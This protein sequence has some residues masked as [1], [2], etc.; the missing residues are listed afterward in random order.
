M[1]VLTAASIMARGFSGT[2]PWTDVCSVNSTVFTA[3]VRP[4]HFPLYTVPHAPLPSTPSSCS[5][6]SVP[7]LRIPSTSCLM[8]SWWHLSFTDL[9][10][11]FA[12]A[13]VTSRRGMIESPT[14][15]SPSSL[16]KEPLLL[17]S[18]PSSEVCCCPAS[19]R[20]SLSCGL[21]PCLLPVTLSWMSVLLPVSFLDICD[22][23]EAFGPKDLFS[24]YS[25][26]MMLMWTLLEAD[27]PQA[28][29][30]HFRRLDNIA[31]ATMPPIS[32]MLAPTPTPTP[33]ATALTPFPSRSSSS[34]TRSS[35][36]SDSRRGML[37][38]NSRL[39]PST[40]QPRYSAS[41]SEERSNLVGW[42]TSMPSMRYAVLTACVF[43]RSFLFAADNRMTKSDLSTMSVTSETRTS[44]PGERPTD[45]IPSVVLAAAVS[46]WDI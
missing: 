6:S 42:N 13:A 5:T 32:M 16:L 43:Q 45:T 46:S 11:P 30:A 36:T 27:S 12:M 29:L 31:I 10:R 2:L 24:L 1:A 41:S 22:T 38:L 23:L 19:A 15:P 25:S 28:S 26:V 18:Q 40:P 9:S 17:V 20:A 3:T 21:A 37:G 44:C 4:C 39:S 14:T 33:M 7:G 8:A 34:S 35:S